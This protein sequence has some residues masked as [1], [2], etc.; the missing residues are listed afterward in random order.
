MKD[1]VALITG[2]SSGIGLALTHR[3]LAEDWQVIAL[4][5]SGFAE[6]DPL[7][8]E[9]VSK[10]RL[11]IYKADLADFGSL[12]AALHGIKAR[13]EK[14]DVLFNNAGGSIPEL[15]FSKQGR[16]LHFEVQTLVP[17]ILLMELKEHL[18]RGTL[19][20]VINTSSNAFKFAER[21]DPNTLER[22]AHFKLLFGPYAATKLAVT[23]WSRE[24]APQ[25]AADGI[26]I[27]SVDPGGSNTLRRDNA[28]GLPFSVRMLMKLFFPPPSRGAS[29]LYEGALGETRDASGVYVSNGKVKELGLVEQGRKVL[30]KVSAIYA[31]EFAADA[32]DDAGAA[33]L[34]LAPQPR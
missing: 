17:Y 1:R 11:R 14:I 9:S 7:I 33:F 26:K 19:K 10:T 5:R 30:E 31:R 23:L 3:L 8:R 32:T 18:R 34:A 15:R 24:I 25:L 2:A 21:F 27:R 13:E 4:I 20:A 16:E 12:R 28:S 6:E 22:P 29:R